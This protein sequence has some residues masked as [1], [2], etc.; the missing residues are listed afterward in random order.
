MTIESGTYIS[1][2]NASNPGASDLKSEGDD[3]IR[4][5][6]SFI[7]ATFPNITGAVTVTQGTLNTSFLP[8]TGGAV[9]GTLGSAGLLQLTDTTGAG[10]NLKLTG[11][12]GVTPNKYIRV[13]AGVF[14]I[15]N[16]GYASVILGITDAGVISN[17]EGNELGFRG[18]PAASVTSGAFV[19]A[20]R[21]KV[22]MAT[23]GVTVPNS[24]MAAQD[25]VHVQNTTGSAI[26]ITAT[27]AT[28]RQ[29]G[30][31]ATGNRQ[32]APYGRCSILFGSPTLAYI[33]GDII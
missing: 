23:A 1:D 20:D 24:T 19:A 32:L 31:T 33:S 25:V 28:L 22:V 17:F 15:L 29:T 2:L 14:G 30:T 21:G 12:G 4:L 7:K 9:A 5:I 8:L 27:V 26:T 13:T 3:H 10:V 11:D 16:S 6:K 18:L